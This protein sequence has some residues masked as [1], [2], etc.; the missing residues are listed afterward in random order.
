MNEITVQNDSIY[1]I[2]TV[3]KKK[4]LILD[5]HTFIRCIYVARDHLYP[6][7]SFPHW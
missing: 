2:D 6:F 3:F 4:L 5:S 7:P 1:Y